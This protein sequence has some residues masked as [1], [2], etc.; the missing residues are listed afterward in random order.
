MNKK[1][2]FFS[3]ELIIVLLLF[4]TIFFISLIVWYNKSREYDKNIILYD[5]EL[6]SANIAELLATSPGHPLNWSINNI[7]QLGVAD[8]YHV[9]NNHKLDKLF[10][11]SQNNYSLM[12]GLLGVPEY[13][14]YIIIRDKDNNIVRSFIKELDYTQSVVWT[15]NVIIN[16]SFYEFKIGVVS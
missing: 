3:A 9:I 13:D 11:L 14:Y 2:Q 10:Y 6:G 8:D 5:I 15:E 1:S 16:N 7:N 12:K 4:I